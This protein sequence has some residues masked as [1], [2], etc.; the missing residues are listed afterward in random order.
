MV[1]SDVFPCL[2]LMGIIFAVAG[3]ASMKVIQYPVEQIANQGESITFGCKFADIQSTS[4]L[5]FYWWKRGEREYLHTSPDNRKIFNFKTF[6]L[7]NVSFHDSGVYLCAVSRQGKTAANGTGSRLIVHDDITL[8]WSKDDNEV[9]TGINSTK[10]RNS[11]GLYEFSSYLE[12]TQP[13]QSGVDY[14]CLVSHISL[15]IPAVARYSV[16]K[17]NTESDAQLPYA[18]IAGCAGGG[19]AF[20]LLLFI[21]GKQWQLSKKKGPRRNQK[22]SSHCEE[23]TM[24]RGENEPVA[25]VTLNL[26]SSKKTPRPKQQESTVYAQTKQGAAEHKLTYAALDL[27]PSNKTGKP[28]SRVKNTEYAELHVRN[29]GGAAAA[30]CREPRSKL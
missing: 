17:S 24:H 23:Q 15:R 22:G 26:T 13:V 6:Q 25:Y 8:T 9:K 18:L 1:A 3:D 10:E 19:L 7:L 27:H 14:T 16:S 28:K 21:I 4:D 30:I 2:S 5:T 20:L 12:E 29:H 11:K